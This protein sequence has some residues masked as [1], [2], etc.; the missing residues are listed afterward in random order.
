MD[1]IVT[2][3]LQW[4]HR[5]VVPIGG[6][7]VDTSELELRPQGKLTADGSSSPSSRK[8]HPPLLKRVHSSRKAFVPAMGN[9]AEIRTCTFKRCK[10]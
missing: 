4:P 6:I 8:E 7:A 1:S 2:D 3:M 10:A 9:G 5:I